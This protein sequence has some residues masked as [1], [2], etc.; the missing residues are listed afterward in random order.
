[1]TIHENW[2]IITGAAVVALPLLYI[3]LKDVVHSVSVGKVKILGRA[4]VSGSHVVD[5]LISSKEITELDRELFIAQRRVVH[6][7]LRSF[8][9]ILAKSYKELFLSKGYPAHTLVHSV[10]YRLLVCYSNEV[11]NEITRMI[12]ND[13]EK[14]HFSSMREPQVVDQYVSN[15][16]SAIIQTI[17]ELIENSFVMPQSS[18]VQARDVLETYRG[19]NEVFDQTF[20]S[21]YN[22]LIAKAKAAQRQKETSAEALTTEL[23]NAGYIEKHN[24]A[25]I[26]RY[27]LGV[28]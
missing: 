25:Q 16:V 28:R 4:S 14:N 10:V 21:L 12:M 27:L 24:K 2:T 26:L 9:A 20:R 19:L 18:K 1:M 23:L 17:H 7:K 3:L 11:R 13:I 15:K 22:E 8:R 6:Q 5:L